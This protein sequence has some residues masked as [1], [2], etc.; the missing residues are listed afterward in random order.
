MEGAALPT[1]PL[2][3]WELSREIGNKT[4]ENEYICMIHTTFCVL[5][6]D[7][8]ASGGAASSMTSHRPLS[9]TLV[10][11]PFYFDNRALAV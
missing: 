1:L 11:D 6:V 4:R 10:V 8:E 2:R 5:F 3:I 9:A 7:D